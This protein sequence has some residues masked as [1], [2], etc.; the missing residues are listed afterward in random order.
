[1]QRVTRFLTR[2][3]APQGRTEVRKDFVAQVASSDLGIFDTH[4]ST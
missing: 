3:V 1:M 2:K 4:T